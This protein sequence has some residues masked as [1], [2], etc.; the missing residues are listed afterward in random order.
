MFGGACSEQR[1]SRK[2]SLALEPVNPHFF[3]FPLPKMP[4]MYNRTSVKKEI[5]L[6]RHSGHAKEVSRSECV[7]DCSPD[8]ANRPPVDER[9][10]TDISVWCVGDVDAV[11]E[12]LSGDGEQCGVDVEERRRADV[13]EHTSRKW[14]D[15]AVAVAVVAKDNGVVVAADACDEGVA[16]ISSCCCRR[17]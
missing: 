9:F 15:N 12:M 5:L 14:R 13:I 2:S 16:R 4:S 10:V 17:C 8:L 1:C 7:A 3:G 6:S 11:A